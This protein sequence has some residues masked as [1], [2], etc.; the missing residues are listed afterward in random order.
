MTVAHSE[1]L[2]IELAVLRERQAWTL[3][4][5]MRFTEMRIC[6]WYERF[7]GKVYVS[8]SGGLDS[9]V[10]L[11]IARSL[12]P[13]IPAVFCDTGLEFPEIRQFVKTIGNVTWLKPKMNFRQVLK[14]YGYPVVSKRNSQYIR[15]VRNARGETATKRL[16]LTGIKSDGAYSSIGKI[17]DK[18]QYLIDAPFQ[19]S[20][21][22]CDVFKKTPMKKYAKETGRVPM[23]GTRADEA[24]QREKTYLMYGCNA[25]DLSSG[26]RS[27]PIAIW[28]HEDIWEYIHQYNLSYSSI[29]DM[30]Y[31]RTGCVFCMFGCHLDTEPNRFQKLE[32][33]HPELHKYC[34]NKLGLKEVLTHLGV[35]HENRQYEI[36][37]AEKDCE[38]KE[39]E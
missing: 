22:C 23:I 15:E 32:L 26:A 20:E 11:D 4:E 27:T 28:R 9:T 8:F 1:K 12:F 19:I 6:E 18:W 36:D 2:K 5:K 39:T 25:F 14:K 21:K 24:M 7:E 29:Y 31:E 3:E 17:S 38:I 33:T 34:M 35:P 37:F 16:R 10:L 13:E 30:G